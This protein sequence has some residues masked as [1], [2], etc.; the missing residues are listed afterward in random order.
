MSS[1]ESQN[2]PG[3]M[4]YCAPSSCTATLSLWPPWRGITGRRPSLSSLRPSFL[5]LRDVGARVVLDLTQSIGAYPIDIK[6]LGPDFMV[7]SGYKWLFCP[8]GVSF[9]YVDD[10]HFD[11]IPI[12][13]AWIDRAGAEDFSRL[14]EFTDSYQPGARRYD[15]SEKSSFSNIAGAVAALEMIEEWGVPNISELLANTNE[16][17]AEI[18]L[19]HGFETTPAAASRATFP[20]GSHSVDRPA[21][22]GVEAYRRRRLCKR[23][24]KALTG[25]AAF[26]YG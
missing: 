3:L 16:R 12:E 7:S 19:S 11:G 25:C 8:Y 6:K 4:P 1:T 15:V 17:I 21:R 10:E 26:V 9:L 5:H 23:S 20:G 13:E 24:R 2:K 22:T 14:S 18:L